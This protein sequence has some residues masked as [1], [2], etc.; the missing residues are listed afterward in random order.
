LSCMFSFLTRRSSAAGGR[1]D[2]RE[3]DDGS[4]TG[5]HGAVSL[6]KCV[7]E[8]IGNEAVEEHVSAA[9]LPV[10]PGELLGWLD[11]AAWE[12]PG[13]WPNPAIVVWMTAL[14]R[15]CY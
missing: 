9:E 15:R 2:A 10:G 7:G 11:C 12:G 1:D 13:I 6:E 8:W 4:D 3:E 14:A 5:V